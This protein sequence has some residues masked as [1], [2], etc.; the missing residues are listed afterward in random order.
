MRADGEPVHDHGES[1]EDRAALD[2][3]LEQT[4]RGAV[5]L[6]GTAVVLMMLCWLAIYVFV[7]LPR[8][9]VG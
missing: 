7:F 4:P 5:A 8:G 1:P 9:S 3:A 2:R 6:A